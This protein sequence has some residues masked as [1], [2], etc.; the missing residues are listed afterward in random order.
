MNTLNKTMQKKISK[1]KTAVKTSVKKILT[2]K[3]PKELTKKELQKAQ[4]KRKQKIKELLVGS[5]LDA[6]NFNI[7]KAALKDRRYDSIQVYLKNIGQ[8]ELIS[9]D[10]EKKLAKRIEKGDEDAK[11]KL[12]RANLRLVVSI[13]K[14]YATRSPDLTILDLIQ[15]GNIGLYKAINKFD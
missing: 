9:V 11:K 10:E 5:I 15:E 8:H 14:K 3:I 2:K 1:K 4:E 13:A 7:D 12:A 6:D